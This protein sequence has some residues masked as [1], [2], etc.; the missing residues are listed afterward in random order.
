MIAL[1]SRHEDSP[2]CCCALSAAL[3]LRAFAD[4]FLAFRTSFALAFLAASLRL[5]AL[6]GSAAMCFSS[7]GAAGCSP[8]HEHMN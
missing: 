5:R 3:C 7:L 6:L 8:L 1:L 4:S 2:S